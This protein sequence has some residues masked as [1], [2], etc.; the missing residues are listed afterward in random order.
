MQMDRPFLGIVPLDRE[1]SG[2]GSPT[3]E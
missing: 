3:V 2:S 1:S